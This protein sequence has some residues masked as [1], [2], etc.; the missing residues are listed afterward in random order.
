MPPVVITLPDIETIVAVVDT[1]STLGGVRKLLPVRLNANSESSKVHEINSK[2]LI[3]KR[4]KVYKD[5]SDCDIYS[6]R[7]PAPSRCPQDGRPRHCPWP[8]QPVTYKSRLLF[9][10]QE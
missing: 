10:V 2:T 3:Y 6:D 5:H 4:D 7:R 9:H 8:Q 1:V